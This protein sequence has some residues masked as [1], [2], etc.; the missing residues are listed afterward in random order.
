M[1]KRFHVAFGV[2]WILTMP[3]GARADEPGPTPMPWPSPPVAPPGPPPAA[4]VATP[5]DEGVG[6]GVVALPGATD[7]AWPLAQALYTTSALR[8]A[9]IDE[10]H[11]R[12]LCGE[13]PLPT[14]DRD[15]RDLAETVAAIHG[16]DAPSR[17]LLGDL[18]RRFGVRGIVLVRTATTADAASARVFIRASGGFDAA[19]YAPDASASP[20][21]WTGAVRS[22]EMTFGRAQGPSSAAPLATHDVP[23]PAQTFYQSPWF[24]GALGVAALGAGAV[25]LITRGT[26]SPTLHL[27]AETPH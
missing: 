23:P 10:A 21:S 24:W 1:D 6:L 5:V 20:A 13:P 25:I 15:L 17:A 27:E 7:A 16:D 19:V 2:L 4:P 12:V 18:V 3:A 22:L 26:G 14:A 8:P 9:G 11:A